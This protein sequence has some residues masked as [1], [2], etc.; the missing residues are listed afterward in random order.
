MNNSEETGEILTSPIAKPAASTVGLAQRKA[1]ELN[2]WM[3]KDTWHFRLIQPPS[4]T[5]KEENDS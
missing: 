2:T 4:Q 3:A 1:K 5:L